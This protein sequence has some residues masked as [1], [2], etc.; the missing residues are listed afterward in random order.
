MP[1]VYCRN[2]YLAFGENKKNIGEIIFFFFILCEE[3]ILFPF[4]F[5]FVFSVLGKISCFFFA[6]MHLTC[7]PFFFL[8]YLRIFF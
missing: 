8:F 1:E 5:L 2:L 4:F 3:N 7:F 6:E